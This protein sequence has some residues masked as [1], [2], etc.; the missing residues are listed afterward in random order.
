METFLTTCATWNAVPTA[1]LSTAVPLSMRR[2]SRLDTFGQS[3]NKSSEILS[4]SRPVWELER[5]QRLF[6]HGTLCSSNADVAPIQPYDS[7]SNPVGGHSGPRIYGH[8]QQRPGA[9][10]ATGTPN[11]TDREGTVTT[12]TNT[13]NTASVSPS[14]GAAAPVPERSSSQDRRLRMIQGRPRSPQDSHNF[15]QQQSQSSLSGMLQPLNHDSFEVGKPLAD[16]DSR[17]VQLLITRFA[18]VER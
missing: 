11:R 12:L 4:L 13:T 9:A 6:D 15:L 16:I 5:L 7:M 1:V 8:A 18:R 2:P 10:D 17:A 14:H 3:F